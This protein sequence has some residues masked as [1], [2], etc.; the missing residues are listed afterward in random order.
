MALIILPLE[1]SIKEHIA[2]NESNYANNSTLII[3]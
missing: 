1:F 2:N 3:L